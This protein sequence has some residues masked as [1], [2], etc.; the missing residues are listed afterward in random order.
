MSIENALREGVRILQSAAQGA[1]TAVVLGSGLGDYGERLTDTV[2]FPYASIPDF[3]VSTVAGH[4]G[5]FII[6]RINGKKIIVLSG[7]FHYY[8]GYGMQEVVL[9][10]RLL[11]KLN[12]R[13]LIL[14]NAAGGVNLDFYPG[15]LMLINDHINLSGSNPLIGRNLDE[16]GPRFPDMSRAYDPGLLA[17]AREAA[18]EQDLDL[19]EGVYCML[20]G[21][22]YETPAE[23]RMLRTL[24][25]D[26]V[27]MSTVPE[28]IAAR[29]A[30]LRVMGISCITNMAAGINSAPLMHQEVVETGLRV[31]ER[32]AA[33]V[34]GIL[35]RL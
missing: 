26:A 23:I 11:A 12:I 31:R 24:G 4:A 16:F 32:F 25:A 30:G 27:G 34:S 13:N 9:P 21:P 3:P 35:G 28:V 29:H 19:K 33:L 22:C 8:E 5:R 17:I 14:T 6:G 18:E 1:D 2:S 15:C 7:R 10:V 20:T